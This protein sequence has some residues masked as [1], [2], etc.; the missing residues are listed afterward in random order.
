MGEIFIPKVIV[1]FKSKN[2]IELNKCS[3]KETIVSKI[4]DVLKKEKGKKDLI[5]T[6]GRT[7]KSLYA[8]WSK[9]HSF[10]KLK[11]I[12][13]FLGDERCV[14]FHHE[15]SN[16]NLIKKNLFKDKIPTNCSFSKLFFENKSIEETINFHEISFPENPTLLLLS[17][18]ID[19]H[20][21]SIFPK[22]K[23]LKNTKKI[24]FH[25][26][27]L[28]INRLSITPKIIKSSQKI[29]VLVEGEEKRKK[30]KEI[31]I[32]KKDIFSHPSHLLEDAYWFLID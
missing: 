9:H 17:F 3:W 20:I 29:F 10:K 4:N 26:S 2:I 13:F 7:A 25:K 1:S 8:H 21:A 24:G 11:N 12:N 16:F 6:G 27:K 19:G 23:L 31:M 5:L 28:K 22:S 18:G 30:F 15:E 32:Q 14:D